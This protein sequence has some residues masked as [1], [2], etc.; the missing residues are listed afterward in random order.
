MAQAVYHKG[1][2]LGDKLR[3]ERRPR[4]GT[5]LVRGGRRVQLAVYLKALVCNFK[6]MVH[7]RLG[8]MVNTAQ[9]AAGTV[10]GI[11]AEGAAPQLPSGPLTHGRG[12]TTGSPLS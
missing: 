2:K 1:R 9:R 8:E 12:N 10:P 6:Q 3:V 5:P 4:T 11:A 7:A